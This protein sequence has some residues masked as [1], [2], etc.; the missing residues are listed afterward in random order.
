MKNILFL[1]AFFPVVLFGQIRADQLPEITDPA[2]TDAIYSAERGSFQKITF[3]TMKTFFEAGK[4]S[5]LAVSNDTLYAYTA[6][7]DTLF[8]VLPDASAANEIQVFDVAELSGTDLLLSLSSDSEA[9]KII[10]LS[11]LQDGTGTDDQTAGE[12]AITDADDYFVSTDVEDALQEVSLSLVAVNDKVDEDLTRRTTTPT[13]NSLP[14]G[15]YFPSVDETGAINGAGGYRSLDSVLVR[16]KVILYTD[17]DI[18][19]SSITTAI[20]D[21]KEVRFA[22]T[23]TDT[24]TVDREIELPYANTSSRSIK[25]V[26]IVKGSSYPLVSGDIKYNGVYISGYKIEDN[27]IVE[28]TPNAGYWEL[29]TNLN[30]GDRFVTNKLFPFYTKRF[31]Q[32]TV[33]GS[34]LAYDELSVP[35]EPKYYGPENRFVRSV[36]GPAMTL[37]GNPDAVNV[38]TVKDRVPVPGVKETRKIEIVTSRTNNSFWLDLDEYPSTGQ[39]VS[40]SFWARLDDATEPVSIY[41][42]GVSDGFTEADP[43]DVLTTEYK[44]FHYVITSTGDADERNE[45]NFGLSGT[46]GAIIYMSQFQ[47]S[48]GSD[49]KDDVITGSDVFLTED[50]TLYLNLSPDSDGGDLVR[51]SDLIIKNDYDLPKATRKTFQSVYDYLQAEEAG[52]GLFIYGTYEVDSTIVVHSGQRT[53]GNHSPTVG[54]E[55]NDNSQIVSSSVINFNPPDSTPNL[56]LFQV[57]DKQ[58]S[59]TQIQPKGH[60]FKGLSL[61]ALNDCEALIEL[62]AAVAVRLTDI[63]INGFYMCDYGVSSQ[64]D[65]GWA[66]GGNQGLMPYFERVYVEGTNERAFNLDRLG[67]AYLVNCRAMRNAGIGLWNRSNGLTVQNCWFENN[68]DDD[69]WYSGRVINAYN[70]YFE[71][72][73]EDTLKVANINV[74]QAL[75]VNIY[76]NTSNNNLSEFVR[77][78]TVNRAEIHGNFHRSSKPYIYTVNT[79]ENKVNSTGNHRSETTDEN[80]QEPDRMPGLLL[81]DNTTRGLDL[82]AKSSLTDFTVLAGTRIKGKRQNLI[83]NSEDIFTVVGSRFT[84]Q[85]GDIIGPFGENVTDVVYEQNEVFTGASS[86]IGFNGDASATLVAD[87]SYVFTFW[88]KAISATSESSLTLIASY[89]N[90]ASIKSDLPKLNGTWEKYRFEFVA[91]A[92][93]N[94][95]DIDLKGI[96]DT[97]SFVGDQIAIC[98]GSLYELSND[99]QG[100]VETT[101]STVDDDLVELILPLDSTLHIVGDV[102]IDG[103]ITADNL[104]V[105]ISATST[106]D[107]GSTAANATT[108]LTISVTGA[109]VGDRVIPAPPTGATTQGSYTAFVSSSDTVTVRFH[110]DDTGVYDPASGSFSVT[111]IQ[112]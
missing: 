98:Y 103:D 18:D 61:N 38:S 8:I 53:E 82:G 94:R 55:A 76:G 111:V 3:G 112:Q 80:A 30:Y 31:G 63:D 17:A 88:A 72:N 54:D 105:F 68:Q 90:S 25:I 110:N 4:L 13:A 73:A 71:P 21:G 19:T 60:T 108:D 50:N 39:D 12:V 36:T 26:G 22:V 107:F 52:A 27:E 33:S 62:E 66:L 7:P 51:A 16:H 93:S 70:N 95:M 75:A 45:I 24:T 109:V 99:P 48:Y 89:N 81:E 9:T 100:Y 44:R 11:S 32:Y 92:T 101:S 46:P 91:D 56:F 69:I 14:S 97:L 74:S 85:T 79:I 40:I 23:L 49:L 37:P 106:L 84:L 78:D 64:R 29:H 104:P 43:Q 34:P 1:I 15:V 47:A 86:L 102:D 59:G 41:I 58:R 87:S 67:W 5:S 2:D 77:L 96:S 28:L 20:S 6:A 10:D 42:E 65:V 83:T 57:D 35:I